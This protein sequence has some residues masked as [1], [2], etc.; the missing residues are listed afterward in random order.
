[1]LLG[2]LKV[3]QEFIKVFELLLVLI[4]VVSISQ[5][6]VKITQSVDCIAY[7][8]VSINNSLVCQNKNDVGINQS[9]WNYSNCC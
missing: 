5:I 4:S 2:L 6:V 3:L 8:F 1:M 7:I 9:C